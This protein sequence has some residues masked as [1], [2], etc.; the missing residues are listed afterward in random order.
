MRSIFGDILLYTFVV[1]H[2]SVGG[3]IEPVGVEPWMIQ[4]KH[5]Q[6]DVIANTVYQVYFQQ[7][8]AADEIPDD[9]TFSKDVTVFQKII[10]C[11]FGRIERQFTETVLADDVTVFAAELAILRNDERNGLGESHPPFGGRLGYWVDMSG[12]FLF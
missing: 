10:H 8:F 5:S 7:G 4:Y 1:V 6:L 3:D 9:G 2:D 12:H 11:L